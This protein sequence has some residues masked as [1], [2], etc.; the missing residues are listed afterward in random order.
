MKNNGRTVPVFFF[1]VKA[2]ALHFSVHPRPSRPPAHNDPV[3][4]GWVKII[5]TNFS[6]RAATHST[7]VP[8]RE[9]QTSGRRESP[10]PQIPVISVSKNTEHES[11]DRKL[12]CA[13]RSTPHLLPASLVLESYPPDAGAVGEHGPVTHDRNIF[14]T[15]V[16]V[17]DRFGFVGDRRDNV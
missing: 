7:A 12:S 13:A 15:P 6:M 10:A 14:S 3:L 8:A 4:N 17:V 1:P 16:V 2:H 9:G 11:N 5:V